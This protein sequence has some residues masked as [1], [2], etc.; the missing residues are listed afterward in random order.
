MNSY[1]KQLLLLGCIFIFSCQDAP[2]KNHGPIKLGDPSTIITET[3]PQR[4]QDLVTDLTPVIPSNITPDTPKAEPKVDT[5]HKTTVLATPP[6]AAPIPSGPGLKAEFKE[7]TIMLPGLDAKQ[8]GKPNLINAN[9]AVYTWING[10]I[11]GNVMRTTG[12][13]TKVSQRY[14]SIVVLRGKNGDL[15]LDDLTVTTPWQQINGGNG[16]YPVRGLGENDLKFDE[17]DANDIRNAVA[18]SCRQR[19]LSKK[20]VDEWMAVLG[21]NV[22]AA[23]QKPLVI[24]L[25]SAMWK[26]DGKDDKGK[27][28]SKQIRI[29][30]PM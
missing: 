16:A 13:V 1:N 4:L 2:K 7:V 3:D 19:R 12:N 22:R 29:D 6:V 28:F 5:A 18:K 30:V 10:N 9:G 15:P 27:I 26:V 20:K 8:A 17:A 21:K 23:N 11:N 14:Q 24:T 25:R